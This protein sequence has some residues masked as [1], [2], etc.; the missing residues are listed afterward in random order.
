MNATLQWTPIMKQFS[1]LIPFLRRTL[2]TMECYTH[3]HPHNFRTMGCQIL[4]QN[5]MME[6][7]Y[8]RGNVFGF[9]VATVTTAAL[10]A[11]KQKDAYGISGDG[12]VITLCNE[13]RLDDILSLMDLGNLAMDSNTYAR[14]LQLCI[15]TKA[16]AEGKR[17]HAHITNTGFKLDIFLQN[18]LVEM[19]AKCGRVAYA[20]RVFDEIP[21]RNVFSW[22]TM[23][24]GYF[25]C[26]NI[27]DARHLFD[28]M[29][30]RDVV[31]WTTIISGYAHCGNC[32]EAL[33]LF[34]QMN[35]A[36]YMPNQFTFASLVC[37]CASANVPAIE[38]GKQVH[39]HIFRTGFMSNVLVG[40]A[41]IDMY[42]KCKN[43]D[44]ARQLFDKMPERDVV[45]WSAMLAGYV[46]GGYGNEAFNLFFSML[47]VGVKPNHF[48]FASALG[49]CAS[50][51]AVDQGKQVH[52][53]IIR[54]GCESNIFVGNALVDM[55]VKCG[56][57]ENGQHVF[58]KMPAVDMVSWTALITG[59]SQ[60]GHGQQAMNLFHQMQQMGVKPD[61]VTFSSILSACASVAAPEQ[62]RQVHA[63]I[64]K[65][66]LVSNVF[67]GSALV[68]MYAKCGNIDDAQEIFNR[69]P[70]RNVVTWNTMIAGYAQNGQAPEALQLYEQMLQ[71]GIKPNYVS[72]IGVISACCHAGL[73]QKGRHYFNSMSSDHC[74]LPR[75]DHY[76]CMVDLFGRAGHL[77]EAED[78]INSMPF[79][80]DATVWGALLGACRIHP[81]IEIGKHAAERLFEL[82]PQSAGPYVLLSNIFAEAG[83]W[84]DVARVRRMMKDRGVRKKPG[85]S[86]IE[87]NNMVHVFVA[88]DRSHPQTEEIY[89]R[90]EGLA[91]Q[92]KAFGYAPNKHAVLHDVEE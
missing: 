14:I 90:L 59:Y 75:S 44:D 46:Q 65:S 48:S 71:V 9:I 86:W 31:S 67:V 68:H 53:H 23:I 15:D 45:S 3:R 28:K 79:E 58:D 10:S 92:M 70:E 60:S 17:V 32:E 87:V 64:I 40:N 50:L 5:H 83:R 8:V 84:D 20:R 18:R 37:A 89:V 62:G 36:G 12:V 91:K 19:Y 63:H 4:N 43:V 69:M 22:N 33:R 73:V 57:T 82:E 6:D 54:S 56:S 85:C 21:K 66:V 13:R 76:A 26:G 49:A 7:L 25:K 47:E 11:E 35:R 1:K 77:E 29:P 78:F 27:E 55:Y 41:L 16:L 61:H 80:P 51:S 24:G 38:Y 88:E 30:E 81:N 39:T 2:L 72:F 52:A 34:N 74:I 42:A